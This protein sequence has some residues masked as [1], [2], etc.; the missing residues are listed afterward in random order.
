MAA[1]FTSFN[2]G[3]RQA[4]AVPMPVAI[5][6][7]T[8][9]METGRIDTSLRFGR[10]NQW[11][12]EQRQ[13]YILRLLEGKFHPDPIAISRKLVGGRRVDR[14][15]NGNNRLRCVRDFK[16]NR[17]GVPVKDD[18]GRTHL[19]YFSEIPVEGTLSNVLPPAYR[20]AFDDYPLLFNVREGLTEQEEISWYQE[21]NTNMVAHTSGHILVARLCADAE[22]PVVSKLLATFPT[23]R[24]RIGDLNRPE[25]ADSLGAYLINKSGAVFN[26]M[27]ERDKRENILLSHAT[28]FNLLANGNT[29]DEKFRG[30]EPTNADLERV[31]HQIR[32]IFEEAT[33]SEELIEE[34][35]TPV[36]SKPYLPTFWHTPYLLGPMAWSLATRQAGAVG[37]WVHFLSHC[38]A[39]T[40]GLAYMN[41]IREK[42]YD[43]LNVRKYQ[44]AYEDMIEWSNNNLG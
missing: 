1:L 4:P 34:W 9:D 2:D 38:T 7:V 23:I 25:D 8:Q 28:L 37:F 36:K 40:I 10:K 33:L 3:T 6:T 44:E 17:F 31:C 27:D 41:A 30:E 21:L 42:K 16:L 29:F 39:G 15:I 22:N 13:R 19:V 26:I 14:A 24:T 12:T 32:T 11:K 18:Q 35:Q 5:R 43:D 20:D